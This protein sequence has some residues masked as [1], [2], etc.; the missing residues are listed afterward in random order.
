MSNNTFTLTF[1]DTGRWE[2]DPF[3]ASNTAGKL[4]RIVDRNSNAL[5]LHY[6][7]QGR[8]DRI[9]DTLGRTNTVAYDSAG[10]V[11][12]LTDFSSRTVTY[13]YY[14]GL[15]GEKGGLGDLASVTSPPVTGTPNK[16]DFPAGKTTTYTYSTGFLDER[17]NHL[18]LTINDPLFPPRR[19][20]ARRSSA[21]R[22]IRWAT[23]RSVSTTHGIAA[24]WRV[25]SRAVPRRACR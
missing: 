17:E 18:L 10:R 25:S 3:D 13:R 20:A 14:Q 12:S 19:A 2:F 22:T 15:P 8:C 6:D 23:W 9:V 11:A 5:T 7:V 16:N 24:C 21:S 4:A 1:P